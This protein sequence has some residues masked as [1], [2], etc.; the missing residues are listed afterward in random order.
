MTTNRIPSQPTAPAIEVRL[1]DRCQRPLPA[2]DKN[3]YTPARARLVAT[4]GFCVCAP[5]EHE[6]AAAIP[7]HS[8]SLL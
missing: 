7:D 4:T 5:G 6:G 1:C 8:P 2:L 3:E